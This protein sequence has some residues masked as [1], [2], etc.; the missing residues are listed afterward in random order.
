M[1]IKW[2]SSLIPKPL[3]NRLRFSWV[4]SSEDKTSI[5]GVFSSCSF[6]PRAHFETSSLMSSFYNYDKLYDVISRMWPSHF[7]VK[8]YVFSISL[9]NNSKSCAYNRA[10]CLFICYFSC[11]A[12]KVPFLAVFTW[13]PVLGKMMRK[14]GAKMANIIGGVTGLQ[15]RLEIYLTSIRRSK[16][17]DWRQNRF[18]ILQHI[19]N[20]GKG[21]HPTPPPPPYTRVGVWICVYVRGLKVARTG[22]ET[23][24]VHERLPLPKKQ[25]FLSIFY[26]YFQKLFLLTISLLG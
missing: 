10:K 5:L 8:I 25:H 12:Q 3:L 26:K 11:K 6:I 15:H 23:S 2:S 7:W 13:F 19:K 24:S 21:F 4:F 18:E 16:V 22:M 9:N 20:S 14:D 17:F 1:W